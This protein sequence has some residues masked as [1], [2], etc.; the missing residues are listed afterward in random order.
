MEF[1]IEKCA[2]LIMESEKRET[3]EG[4]EARKLSILGNTRNPTKRNER[5]SKKIAP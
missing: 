1:G 4:I 3:A 2:M 5:N